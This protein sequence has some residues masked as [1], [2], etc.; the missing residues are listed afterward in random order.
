[1][2]QRG[3]GVTAP[4]GFVA[5]AVHAGIKKNG[6]PDLALIASVHE[7]PI[8]GVFTRNRI[9]AAPVILDRTHLR[10]KIG[11]GILINSGNANACTGAR[12]LADARELAT[13]VAGQIGT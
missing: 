5:A 3:N 8:A 6:V 4:Q 13:L 7:G 12:G 9:A 10:Q 2:T 1:M 11:R